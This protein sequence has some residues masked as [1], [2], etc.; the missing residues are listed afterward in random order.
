MATPERLQSPD[1]RLL[2]PDSVGLPQNQEPLEGDEM[3]CELT[4]SETDV[5]RL[6]NHPYDSAAFDHHW[7]PSK[8]DIIVPPD[9]LVASEE[10]TDLVRKWHAL[11]QERLGYTQLADTELLSLEQEIAQDR[12]DQTIFGFEHGQQ[13]GGGLSIHTLYSKRL[14]AI[15]ARRAS[16][17]WIDAL[18]QPN[19]SLVAELR[20][21]NPS[22]ES[23]ISLSTLMSLF[24]KASEDEVK[25]AMEVAATRGIC[26]DARALLENEE[27]P[28]WEADLKFR[29]EQERK[30]G[31]G[32][33]KGQPAH[34]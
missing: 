12:S 5:S 28:L 19:P 4:Q 31:K 15:E 24:P 6:A 18:F 29:E 33:G 7:W 14:A 9:P 13:S 30:M 23:L 25:D 17:Q 8:A 20:S 21:S 27:M 16:S 32:I 11:R 10:G 3:G 2:S 26:V 22:S 1:E 34:A